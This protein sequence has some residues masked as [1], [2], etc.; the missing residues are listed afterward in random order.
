MSRERFEAYRQRSALSGK[1][2]RVER[3]AAD[4]ELVDGRVIK[5]VHFARGFKWPVGAYV[6][7]ERV[8]TDWQVI[9]NGPT[10]SRK[11]DPP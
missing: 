11:L 2:I 9:G 5:R 10:F 8:E 1:I 3:G 7:I 4:V 6:E